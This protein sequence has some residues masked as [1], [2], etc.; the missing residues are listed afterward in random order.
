MRDLQ[1]RVS[2]T[3]QIVGWFSTV[4]GGPMITTFT[5]DIHEE[6]SA[7]L[8]KRPVHL[9]I[10]TSLQGDA[11]RIKAFVQKKNSVTAQFLVLFQELPVVLESSDVEKIGSTPMQLLL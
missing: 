1:R 4:P 11:L 3:E 10:D 9:V 7:T 8:A 2:P 5:Y 6:Y